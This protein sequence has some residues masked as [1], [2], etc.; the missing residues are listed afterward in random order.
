MCVIIFD[1]PR[2]NG[3]NYQTHTC[4]HSTRQTGICVISP[5]PTPRDLRGR[6]LHCFNYSGKPG[7]TRCDVYARLPGEKP[8]HVPSWRSLQTHTH[9]H[10]RTHTHICTLISVC[11][12][13]CVFCMYGVFVHVLISTHI[14]THTHTQAKLSVWHKYKNLSVC[15]CLCMCC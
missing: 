8:T 9:A 10:T 15:V 1:S 3:A 12:C 2:C 13:V 6:C 7:I 4:R 14:H 5:Y 11:V